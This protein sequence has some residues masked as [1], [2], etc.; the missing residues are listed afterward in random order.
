MT[1]RL[2]RCALTL[3]VVTWSA[4]SAAA[5]APRPPVATLDDVV[6]ELR[7]LRADVRATSR[8]T[9]RVHALVARVTLQEQRLKALSEQLRAASTDV[10]HANAARV[11]QERRLTQLEEAQSSDATRAE[12]QSLE[13]AIK[14]LRPELAATRERESQLRARALELSGLV[15]A[16][17]ARWVEFNQRLDALEDALQRP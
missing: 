5:Q 12:R 15:A 1:V 3:G 6:R 4:V 11:D 2:A 14:Q 9:V 16:E 13:D 8:A 7:E 10:E 17:Q